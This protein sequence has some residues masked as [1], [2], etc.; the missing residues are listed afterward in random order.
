MIDRI[1]NLSRRDLLKLF[2]ISVGATMANSVAGPVNVQAQSKKVTPRK[3]V[4]NVLVIQNCGAMS[5]QE[6]L[7]FKDTR[8]TAKDLDMQKVNSDFYI[9]KAIRYAVGQGAQIINMSF[10]TLQQSGTLKSAVSFALTS[11][12]GSVCYASSCLRCARAGWMI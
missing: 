11:F 2:G 5:P 4:R 6:C 7:D 3:N 10:G 9:S 12:T 8:Y 1:A